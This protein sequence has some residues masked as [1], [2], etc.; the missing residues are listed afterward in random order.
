MMICRLSFDKRLLIWMRKVNRNLRKDSA[1]KLWTTKCKNEQ[2]GAL[3][4]IS[5]LVNDLLQP[6][7]CQSPRPLSSNPGGARL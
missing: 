7:V 6:F 5:N 2:K 1:L 4:P 3:V